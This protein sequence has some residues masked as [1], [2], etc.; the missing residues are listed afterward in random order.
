MNDEREEIE[1]WALLSV[2]WVDVIGE[3]FDEVAC[4]SIQ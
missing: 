1:R 4:E 2:E 3:K